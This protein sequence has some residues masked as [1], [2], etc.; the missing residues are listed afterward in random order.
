[1]PHES[2][3]NFFSVTIMTYFC[4]EHTNYMA[5]YPNFWQACQP[6]GTVKKVASRTTSL[7]LSNLVP[8]LEEVPMCFKMLIFFP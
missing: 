4:T 5:G 8:S 3:A 2:M 1:M 6:L 7:S